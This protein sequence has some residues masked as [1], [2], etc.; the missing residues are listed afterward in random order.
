ICGGV[1]F[2]FNLGGRDLW[3]PDET[4]YAVIAREMRESGN[5]ILPHL[6]GKVYAE[7]PP[8]FFWLINL[9]ILFT[10]E[11]SE[12]ITRL[13]SAISGLATVILTFF[14]GE[15][16]FNQKVG[17]FSSLILATCIFF[18][19]ISRWV[20][21]DSLLTIFFVLALYY[22][23]R[24]LEEN[25]RQKTNYLLAGLFMGLGVLVK[26]PVAYLPIP[27]FLI[28]TFFQKNLKKFWCR[29]LLWSLFLSLGIVSVWLGPVCIVGGK[30]YIY[31]I[32]I[33]KLIGTTIEGGKHFHSNPLYFYFTRFPLEFFPWI[34]FLPPFFIHGWKEES[35]KKKGF[36][37][38]SVWFIFIF[39]FFTLSK[40]KKDNYLL[41]LYPAS[42]MMVGVLWDGA[43]RFIQRKKEIIIGLV[44]LM[45]FFLIGILIFLSEIPQKFY[46]SFIEFRSIGILVFLYLMGGSGLAFIF[47][48]R[49]KK[50]ASF[51]SIVIVFTL[52]HLHLSYVLPQKLNS[53]RSIKAFSERI[54]KRM[55]PQDE[56]KTYW[57]KSNG[58]IYYT[59]QP[60]IEEI[61]DPKRFIEVYHSP[62][63]VFI[64]I[65]TKMFEKLKKD[66][67]IEM[68]PIDQAKVGHWN[69]I[70]ISNH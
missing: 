42:A 69:Y 12:F 2:F 17:F 33:K 58:L 32:I 47:F 57:F 49:R 70:L 59:K 39:L 56:I 3:D 30:D 16:L 6:N 52:F 51:I 5:W 23:Y 19:A 64:V 1:I 8:L 7:K 50:M 34:V 43:I 28:F 15:R 41:P 44:L 67:G 36:L 25:E 18:P 31:Q 40:G 54:I 14:F 65:F 9:F 35:E 60:Y 10:G 22:F 29:D 21:L 37:F 24:G 46:P 11:D 68:N 62:R 55:E 4:R 20:M 63:R 45:L 53:Q 13:P 66:T 26:G 38:L 61:E 27:I 48:I